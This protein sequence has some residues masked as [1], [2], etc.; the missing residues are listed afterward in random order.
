MNNYL[1][2]L[3]FATL[4]AAAPGPDM[5]LTIQATVLGGRPRGF[6]TIAGIV[7][8]ATMQGL[9]VVWGLAAVLTRSQPLF[10]ALRVIGVLYLL[11]MGAGAIRA[12]IKGELAP[13]DEAAEPSPS[14]RRLWSNVRQ[15]FLCN[16]TNPKV[17]MFNLA[18]L[19]QFVSNDAPAAK[20]L[21]YCLTLVTVGTAVLVAVALTANAARRA[22]AKPRARR[23]VN[24]ATGTV[25]VGFAAALAAEA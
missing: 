24:A 14:R 13:S 15:G 2:F 9:L 1:G 19:P 17:L 22:L 18:V 11:Y 7:V 21:V 12:A 6:A 23:C 8:A 20:L 10:L 16:I 25:M 4:V 5:L 3:M